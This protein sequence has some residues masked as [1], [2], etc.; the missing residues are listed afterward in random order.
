MRQNNKIAIN[1]KRLNKEI[2]LPGY[3]YNGDAGLDLRSAVDAVIMPGERKLI[4]TGI[5]IEIPDSYAGFVQP[6]SGLAIK[7]GISLVNTP[8]LIDSKY[9]GE[10]KVILIN[11]D[12]SHEFYVNK[13][14]KIAQL[15][16]QKVADVE[17]VEIESVS[18]TERAEKGFGS[19]G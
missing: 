12:N 18:D 6:R 7:N 4:P 9:R 3:A 8:G 11:L 10:I 5:I 19:S 15:V 13:G 1:V 16:I 2:P 14:D 17:L